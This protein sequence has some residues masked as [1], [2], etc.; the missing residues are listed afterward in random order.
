VKHVCVS[1][2]T[3]IVVVCE[4]STAYV[5]VHATFCQSGTTLVLIAPG[6]RITQSF[7]L[8]VFVDGDGCPGAQFV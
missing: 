2:A 1:L 6:T 5:D 4:H 3:R 8:R 7:P